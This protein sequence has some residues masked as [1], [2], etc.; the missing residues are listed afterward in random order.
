MDPL[1]AAARHG[2]WVLV[3]GLAV[4]LALP[5]LAAV[6]RPWLPVLV[7]VLLFVS[8]LRIRPSALIGS[9][10]DVPRVLLTALALQLMAPLTVVLLARAMGIQDSLPVLALTLMLAAPSIMGSPN[11]S[12]ML[13]AAPDHAMRLMVA[14]TALMPLTI[15]PV[16]WLLPALGGSGAVSGAALTLL[17]TISVVTVVAMALRRNFLRTPSP[18][19][20]ARLE[21]VSAIALAVFVIGLMPQV[22]TVALSEPG[23][24]AFWLGFVLLANLGGQAIVWHLTRNRMPRDHALPISLIA[25]NRNVALFLVSLPPEVTA[26]LM[27]FIGCYQLPMYLTPLIMRRLYGSRAH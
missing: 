20:E 7:V 5:S 11:I 13:G 2:P 21:G 16:F 15:L 3:A 4:G 17:I 18:T 12:M 10:S 24:V 8:V 14:G 26:P 22:S 9:L 19:Q 25:G 23:K 1:I 6:L 27:V